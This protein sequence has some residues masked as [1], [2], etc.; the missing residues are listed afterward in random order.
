MPAVQ[1]FLQHLQLALNGPVNDVIF[2]L[3]DTLPRPDGLIG[4]HTHLFSLRHIQRWD[5]IV[6]HDP[7]ELAGIDMDSSPGLV[8][9]FI[10]ESLDPGFEDLFCFCILL[11]LEFKDAFGRSQRQLQ[12]GLVLAAPG[13]G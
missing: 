12:Q 13:F 8:H 6:S 5:D 2:G 7:I 10:Q 4:H 11:K 1:F 3:Q 9:G